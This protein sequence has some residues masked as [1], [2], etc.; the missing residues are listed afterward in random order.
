MNGQLPPRQQL[1]NDVMYI[2]AAG[3]LMYFAC[4]KY[5][6]VGYDLAQIHGMVLI[7]WPMYNGKGELE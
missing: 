4:N 7:Y 6:F 5:Y 1:P 2:G 3:R